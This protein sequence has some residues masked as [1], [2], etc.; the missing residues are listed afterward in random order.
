M[1]T[2]FVSD[3]PITDPDATESL[4][5]LDDMNDRERQK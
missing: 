2:L 1:S 5:P 4:F 3:L